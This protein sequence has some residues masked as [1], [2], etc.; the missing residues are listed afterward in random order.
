MPSE[1]QQAMDDPNFVVQ[2]AV[3][4]PMPNLI[5]QNP[6]NS[7]R[8]S[9]I[10]YNQ[11]KRYI[12]KKAHVSFDD[13]RIFDCDTG[14]VVMVSHHPGKNPYESFDPLGITNQDDYYKL[15]GVEW[16]SLC[17]ITGYHGF[18]HEIKI[19]PKSI[20]RHGRQYVMHGND[21]I[22]T[23]GKLSKLKTKS[24]RPHF[25]VCLGK[26]GDKKVIYKCVADMMGRTVSILNEREELVA[27]MAKSTKAL[28]QM[29][30]F[31][32]GTESTIDIAPG[33][34][35]SVILAIVYGIGQIGKHLLKD[36]AQSAVVAPMQDAVMDEVVNNVGCMGEATDVYEDMVENTESLHA[37]G[38]FIYES[39]FQ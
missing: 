39:F 20:S 27:Q 32:S 9:G 8:L 35:C 14:T 38:N 5:P 31:G 19:R 21:T 13:N 10:Y 34:D 11:P 2:F 26:G 23:I 33:V 29:A 7:M 3:G 4:D 30:T 12:F 25:G 36:T 17:T 1:I 18:P 15:Y 6:N 37:V 22:M 28:I 16:K 24:F